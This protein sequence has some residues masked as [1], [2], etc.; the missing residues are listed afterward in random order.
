MK[1][2]LSLV[3]T[4]LIASGAVA[5]ASMNAQSASAFG[6]GNIFPTASTSET[7]G[8]P[9]VDSFRF[10]VVSN[11]ANSVLF[12]I[13]NNNN[14]AATGTNFFIG[15][16]YFNQGATGLLS[17]MAINNAN[18]SASGVSFGVDGSAKNFAQGNKI[19]FES[20]FSA[21]KN[22]AA[23]NG[24]NGGE[25]L[26]LTFNGNLSNVVA[27][28]NSGAL[29]VGLHVQGLPNGASD[30]FASGIPSGGS[31][32]QVPEPTTMLGSALALGLFA[33]M[34]KRANNA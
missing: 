9:F 15:G 2:Q 30:S 25:F 29:Q 26:G 21:T 28:L 33:K 17:N 14:A 11:G 31:S 6:F 23:A 16:V 13:F 20:A 12:K 5:I 27:A 24:V 4:I 7:S 32:G 1:T 22:G 19:S 8:D 10:D 3:K 18:T 34:K